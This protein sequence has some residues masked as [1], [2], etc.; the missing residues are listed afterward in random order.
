[1]AESVSHDFV[2]HDAPMPSMSKMENTFRT[3]N[4]FE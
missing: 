3:T 1:M 4:C 2:G